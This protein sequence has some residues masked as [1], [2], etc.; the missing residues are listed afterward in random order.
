MADPLTISNILQLIK[1][2]D[3]SLYMSLQPSG[4]GINDKH[5]AQV[6]APQSSAHPQCCL[7]ARRT[8]GVLSELE[9]T[10]SRRYRM[11]PAGNMMELA[12]RKIP[13][14]KDAIF[15]KAGPVKS[16]Q[17]CREAKAQLEVVWPLNIC[18]CV[19][20]EDFLLSLVRV[21]QS[22]S[23]CKNL[24]KKLQLLTLDLQLS[25]SCCAMGPATA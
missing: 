3:G 23:L 11:E 5:A 19:T 9:C 6:P 18:R 25:D 15:Y 2:S 8:G 12:G 1:F 4:H 14:S 10:S 7:V 20:V 16:C 21:I 13:S 24:Q 22:E 17:S